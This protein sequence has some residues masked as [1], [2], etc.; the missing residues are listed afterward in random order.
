[1]CIDPKTGI[2]Y[3]VYYDRRNTISTMT[4]VY[5]ARSTDGGKTFNNFLVS[6]SAFEATTQKFLGDYINIVA[7]NGKVYPVWIRSDLFGRDVIMAKIDES[8]L[9]IKN[10]KILS[11]YHLYQNY[12]NPFYPSTKISWQSPV[13]SLQ[14]LKVFDV[15]G[16]EVASLVDEEKPAGTYDL[17]W[18]ASN[19][20]SGVYFYQLKTGDFINTKKMLLLK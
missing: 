1:M 9:D 13:S 19:L 11:S 8:T 20:P 6:E 3:I 10:D 12:P 15:L 18:N 16:K 2:I 4:E 5:V 7:Y 14:T 17:I